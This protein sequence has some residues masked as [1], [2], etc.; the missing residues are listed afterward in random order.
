MKDSPKTICSVIFDSVVLIHFAM[1]YLN[2]LLS[3]SAPYK[4]DMG[5]VTY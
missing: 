4:C 1:Y 5:L 2:V 3:S